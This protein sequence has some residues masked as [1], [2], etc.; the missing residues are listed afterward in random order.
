MVRLKRRTDIL[1]QPNGWMLWERWVLATSVGE[2]IGLGLVAAGSA[3]INTIETINI[4]G[5]LLTI[6]ILEGASLGFT[7]WLVLRRYIKHS[8]WWVLATTVGALIAWL[9]GLFVSLILLVEFAD[10]AA[11]VVARNT[12]LLN[13]VALLGA[14]VGAVLGV[15]Q[16]LVLAAHIRKAIWWILANALAWSIGLIVAFV[17]AGMV[18]PDGFS[19]KAALIGATTG[20]TVGAVIGAITGVVLVWLLKRRLR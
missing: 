19:A 5:V 4:H 15:S 3:I 1:H 6:G 16:W 20:I 17:G 8:G 14:V 12:A 2:F 13:G 7:Q 10:G 9:V 18:E 11:N